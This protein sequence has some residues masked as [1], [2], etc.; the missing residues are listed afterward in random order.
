[1]ARQRAADAADVVVGLA[2]E[3]TG[4][5][6]AFLP[7]PREGEGEEGERATFALDL[8]ED[9]FDQLV[10]LEAVA[11]LG[12]RLDEGASEAAAGRWIEERQPVQDAAQRFVSVAQ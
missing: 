12:G 10:V 3:Q 8:G 2:G 9:L 4:L 6:V 7:Q 5:A 1:M 11:A